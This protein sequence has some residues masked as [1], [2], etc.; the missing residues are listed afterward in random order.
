MRRGL[1]KK[2]PRAARLAGDSSLGCWALVRREPLSGR[3]ERLVPGRLPEASVP[4]RRVPRVRSIRSTVNT[5]QESSHPRRIA[6]TLRRLMSVQRSTARV[7]CPSSP[8]GPPPP[9]ACPRARRS[10]KVEPW[11]VLI[12]RH[13]T[14]P[15]RRRALYPSGLRLPSVLV[16]ACLWLPPAPADSVWRIAPKPEL[17][18]GDLCI[19]ACS[20]DP[21]V[22]VHAIRNLS[23]IAFGRASLRWS[24][25][26]FGRTSSTSTTQV[27]PRNLFGF[28]DGT[29]N[30]K[31]EQKNL[32]TEQ[33][34]VASSDQPAW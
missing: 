18:G 34:W 32:L 13:L 25:L 20:D 30:V 19:Q 33:V 26:G 14:T 15:A 5:R 22:A 1:L 24:Q 11:A 2:W 10:P 3:G 28:K 4:R 8:P 31:A 16:P 27:T 29:A 9:H 21:Q 6:C 23:R 17:S 12:T 7:L